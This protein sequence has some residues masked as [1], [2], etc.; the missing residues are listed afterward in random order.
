[1]VRSC[2]FLYNLRMINILFFKGAETKI[3]NPNEEGHGEICVRG[4][5][6]FMG[7][8]NDYEKTSMVPQLKKAL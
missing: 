4:R 6:V 1:M 8:I 2:N 3:I 5:N 7:Y